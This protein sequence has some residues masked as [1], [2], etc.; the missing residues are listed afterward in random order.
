MA[1]KQVTLLAAFLPYSRPP[2]GLVFAGFSENGGG[3]GT[4][5]S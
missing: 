5:V 1:E 4:A 3:W 2:D